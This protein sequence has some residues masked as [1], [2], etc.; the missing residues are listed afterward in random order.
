[1]QDR[2]LQAGRR[3]ELEQVVGRVDHHLHA[4]ALALHL[5]QPLGKER[6]V[7][8]E[9]HV[10]C[11]QRLQRAL[12][13]ADCGNADAR[14]AGNGIDAHL[15]D[16]EAHFLGRSE[17]GLDVLAAGAEIADDGDSLAGADAAQLELLAEEPGQAARVDFLRADRGMHG[18]GSIG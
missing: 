15:V 9:D 10:G 14:P 12:A 8:D 2:L 7:E 18:Y 17:G 3:L 4:N 16:V 1:M 13:F 11:T 6:H 5:A